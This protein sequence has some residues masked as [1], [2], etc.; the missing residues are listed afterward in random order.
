MNDYMALVL[1][2]MLG[3]WFLFSVLKYFSFAQDWII[4]KDGLQL[5]PTWNFFA[6]EPNKTDYYLYYRVFSE[7]SDSCWR[8]VSFGQGRKWYAF[9]WNP[10]RRDRKSLFDLCQMLVSTSSTKQDE[11]VYS[12]PYLLLL[13]HVNHLCTNDI[14]EYVQFAIGRIVPI[15]DE[16][17]LSIAFIS[18]SHLLT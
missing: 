9:L 12:M 3:C 16:G 4:A 17:R 15:E 10:N 2:G 11:L 14:G 13:N 1:A 18:N 7:H 5:V 8:S 6:P